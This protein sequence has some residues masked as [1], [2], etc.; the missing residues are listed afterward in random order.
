MQN[1]Q[2]KKEVKNMLAITVMFLAVTLAMT[3]MITFD[4]NG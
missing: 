3:L 2:G 1:T 4:G